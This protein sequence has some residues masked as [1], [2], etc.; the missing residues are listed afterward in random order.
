MRLVLGSLVVLLAGVGFA[1]ATA[2]LALRQHLQQQTE[3]TLRTAERRIEAAPLGRQISLGPNALQ[4]LLPSDVFVALLDE[5]GQ[6]VLAS[7]PEGSGVPGEVTG[8]VDVGDYPEGRLVPVPTSDGDYLMLRVDVPA[9]ATVSAGDAETPVGSVLFGVDLGPNQEATGTLLRTELLVLLLV[10]V[11]WA[12]AAWAAV[13]VA[14]R[15]LS[16]M[17]RAAQGMAKGDPGPLPWSHPGSE[18]GALAT[19]LNDAFEVRAQAEASSRAFLAD[20][21]HELRT[22]LAAIQA[23]TE[24]YRVGGLPDDDAVREAMSSMESDAHA[25]S[26][27]VEQ[28]LELARLESADPGEPQ[29]VDLATLA[30]SVCA[31]MRPLAGDRVSVDAT[32]PTWV[33]GDAGQLGSLVS[34]LVANAVVHAGGEARIRVRVT[35]TGPV[36]EL[37]VADDGIGM[38]VE[39]MSRA[40]DRFWR[41]DRSRSRPTGSGLGL[42]IAA[43]AARRHGGRL[44]LAAADPTGLVARVSLPAGEPPDRP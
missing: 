25:M 12:L 18:T 4:S 37:E 10:V 3:D 38:T 16:A 26:D 5:S 14:L 9:E 11:L 15:P 7:G 17:A 19:A 35:Q 39:E 43:E 6:V 44:D 34:N 24:L 22:P 13:G 21:S 8:S 42:A 41:A 29:L 20:A 23:W 31:S 1:D 28:M 40:C 33:S 30:R 36:V 27:V 2:Y 32:D